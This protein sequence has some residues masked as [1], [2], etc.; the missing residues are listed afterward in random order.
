MLAGWWPPL[1]NSRAA[2]DCQR[3]EGKLYGVLGAIGDPRPADWTVFYCH[4]ARKIDPGRRIRFPG[5]LRETHA[6]PQNREE[7]NVLGKSG[8]HEGCLGKPESSPSAAVSR[9]KVGGDTPAA[10]KRSSQRSA[11]SF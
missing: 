4:R 3:G 11:F 9:N 8:Q 10:S 6:E 5:L 2:S 7:G 1:A